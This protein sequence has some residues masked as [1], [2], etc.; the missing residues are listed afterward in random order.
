VILELTR[1]ELEVVWRMRLTSVQA[2]QTYY[3]LPGMASRISHG[4]KVS[5]A[6]RSN[7]AEPPVF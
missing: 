4:L 7:M 2:R 1:Q 6:V 3:G 5:Q